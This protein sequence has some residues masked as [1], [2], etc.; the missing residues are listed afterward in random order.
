MEIRRLKAE[1]RADKG[2]EYI[3]RRA[4]K[5]VLELILYRKLINYQIEK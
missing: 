5:L 1:K 2:V 4:P 3:E